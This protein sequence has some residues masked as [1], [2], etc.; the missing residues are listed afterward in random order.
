MRGARI[1]R[2]SS[3]YSSAAYGGVSHG[4]YVN[5][6]ALIGDH[7]SPET[8]LRV[9][10]EIEA[11]GGRRRGVGW[12]SRSLDMDLLDYHGRI[13][14]KGRFS[15]ARWRMGG[16]RSLR[17]PHPDMCNRPF[18]MMPLAEIAPNWHHPVTGETAM[19]IA[20]RLERISGDSGVIEKLP[21]GCG[22]GGCL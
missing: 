9:F 5:A 13:C 4:R 12:G 7:R 14:G 11:A 22:G 19:R 8:L 2:V 15:R 16:R 18:V 6:V 1:L 20:R 3:M 10:H 21:S 17:L